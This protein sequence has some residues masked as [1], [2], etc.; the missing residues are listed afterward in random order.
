MR[1]RFLNLA[2]LFFTMYCMS[3][4]KEVSEEGV[5]LYNFSPQTI[6][7]L[8]AYNCEVIRET[9]NTYSYIQKDCVHAYT[10]DIKPHNYYAFELSLS[11]LSDKWFFLEVRTEEGEVYNKRFRHEGEM[12]G[13]IVFS[14]DY[15]LLD[16]N[17]P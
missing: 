5:V 12:Y 2:V 9:N 4:S 15:E 1:K 10:G 7:E 13:N 14:V 17:A 11:S 8:K 6:K 16:Y 3:C